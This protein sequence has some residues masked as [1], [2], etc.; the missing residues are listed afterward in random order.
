ML[1]NI[2]NKRH[3]QASF[4]GAVL[5]LRAESIISDLSTIMYAVCITRLL[6]YC[7]GGTS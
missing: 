2:Y 7:K 6:A 4:S 1:A 3:K 5:F